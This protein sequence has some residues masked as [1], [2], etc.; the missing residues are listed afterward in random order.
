MVELLSQPHLADPEV[1]RAGGLS[2]HIIDHV[3]GLR[4][5]KEHDSGRHIPTNRDHE[6]DYSDLLGLIGRLAL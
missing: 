4:V 1:V 6:A 5:G 3:D 2:Y